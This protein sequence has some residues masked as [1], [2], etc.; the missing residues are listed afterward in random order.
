MALQM[1]GVSY[2][3]RS[4]RSIGM[5][6]IL[7]CFRGAAFPG[8]DARIPAGMSSSILRQPGAFQERTGIGLPSHELAVQFLGVFAVAFGEDLGAELAA[9][10]A[11]EDSQVA[12][13]GEGVGIQHF[14]PLVGVVSGAIA[15]RVGEQVREGAGY[16]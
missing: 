5:N 3:A 13:T 12:E 15:H 2:C 10:F 11:V 14:G 1:V 4:V 16:Y 6:V 7:S 8:G 9:D